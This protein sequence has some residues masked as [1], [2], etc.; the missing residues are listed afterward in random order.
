MKQEERMKVE[1]KR[2]Q[3]K[4]LETEERDDA[5]NRMARWLAGFFCSNANS[6]ARTSLHVQCDTQEPTLD[7]PDQTR[8]SEL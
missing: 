6:E 5:H 2:K 3:Q 4:W 7:K 8:V 1:R